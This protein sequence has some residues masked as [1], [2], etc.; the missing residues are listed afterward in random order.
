MCLQDREQFLR[1]L[2]DV[3]DTL[4]PRPSTEWWCSPNSLASPPLLTSPYHQRAPSRRY[5]AGI[6]LHSLCDALVA[7][8]SS[9]ARVGLAMRARLIDA[10]VAWL[11]GR[12]SNFDYL[13]AL[14]TAAGRTYNDLIQYPIFPWVIA[15]SSFFVASCGPRFSLLWP[16]TSSLDP[17]PKDWDVSPNY[18]PKAC[19]KSGWNK[20]MQ[21]KC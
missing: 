11:R 13:M 10:Q 4:Q 1:T 21:L 18:I 19:I 3:C 7:P 15:V 12:I 5:L 9:P 2:A 6:S 17:L 16:S 14:N 20:L 8:F